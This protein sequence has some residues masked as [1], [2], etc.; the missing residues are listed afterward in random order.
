MVPIKSNTVRTYF[1]GKVRVRAL[2]EQKFRFFAVIPTGCRM[3]R[4]ESMLDTDIEADN[5][6]REIDKL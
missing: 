3:K 5:T 2:S 1:V 4:S 6:S